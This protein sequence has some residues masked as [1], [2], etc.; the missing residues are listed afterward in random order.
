VAAAGQER[1]PPRSSRRTEKP[2]DGKLAG[3]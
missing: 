3:W 1:I 2:R